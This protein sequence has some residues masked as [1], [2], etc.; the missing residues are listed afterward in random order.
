[1]PAL[2]AAQ[3]WLRNVTRAQLRDYLTEKMHA[4]ADPR[5]PDALR[6]ASLKVRFEGGEEEERPFAHPF[7]WGAFYFTGADAVPSQP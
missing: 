4:Y 6:I 5:V 1:M 2:R 3:Q 7:N